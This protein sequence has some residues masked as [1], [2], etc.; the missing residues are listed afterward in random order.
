MQVQVFITIL[1]LKQ[2]YGFCRS[3]VIAGTGIAV[4]WRTP[5]LLLESILWG[6]CSRLHPVGQGK[7]SGTDLWKLL[8][9]LTSSYA[10]EHIEGDCQSYTYMYTSRRRPFE[11][12]YA[13]PAYT[14]LIQDLLIL[15]YCM[16]RLVRRLLAGALIYHPK[17]G[18]CFAT[19]MHNVNKSKY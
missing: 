15:D 13:N 9:G 4:T 6:T 3:A 17:C 1:L 5:R 18:I 12:P 8:V 11:N 7:A 16:L 2:K 14:S 19:H 10:K